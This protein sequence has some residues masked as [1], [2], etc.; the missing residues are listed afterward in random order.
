MDE[1]RKRVF[2]QFTLGSVVA[3]CVAL[4]SAA[5]VWA[6]LRSDMSEQ[7][8]RMELMEKAADQKRDDDKVYKENTRQDLRDVK[9]EIGEIKNI[10]LEMNRAAKR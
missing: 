9:K 10:L 2:M 8:A 5:G 7:K 3:L 1:R 4:A 6:Q